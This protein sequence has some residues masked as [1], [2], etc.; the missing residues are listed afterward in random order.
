MKEYNDLILF[1]KIYD[2]F[3]WLHP[4]LNRFPKSEKFLLA[5][6]IERCMIEIVRHAVRINFQKIK[7]RDLVEE[8][9]AELD[10]LKIL[11]RL[12]KDLR[13]VSVKSYGVFSEK[14]VEVGKLLGGW[15]KSLI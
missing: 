14:A 4:I 1:Q 8:M 11:V 7:N 3:L 10:M 15:Q 6:Q 12:S 13:F 2:L 9:S 5:E